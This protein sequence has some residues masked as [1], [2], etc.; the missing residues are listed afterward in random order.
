MTYSENLKPFMTET[1]EELNARTKASTG[2]DMSLTLTYDGS[3]EIKSLANARKITIDILLEDGLKDK[4]LSVS[5]QVD[6]IE[7]DSDSA[8][9][10]SF[11]SAP[12]ID[13]KIEITAGIASEIS[14]FVKDGTFSGTTA[15]ATLSENL[16]PFLT[17]DSGPLTRG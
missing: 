6:V 15:T 5:Y 14:F 1:F 12:D 3:S 17:V 10:P 7:V 11:T 4:S 9:A 13:N 8:T 16:K 2:A